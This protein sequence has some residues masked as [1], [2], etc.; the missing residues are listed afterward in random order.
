MDVWH[1]RAA[2]GLGLYGAA[3]DGSLVVDPA[4]GT[5]EASAGM[6]QFLGVMDD[7]MVTWYM[8]LEGGYDVLQAGLRDDDISE[9]LMRRVRVPDGTINKT[10]NRVKHRVGTVRKSLG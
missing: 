9:N 5:F 4:T 3:N 6:A 8:D 1:G 10:H 7:E 2:G